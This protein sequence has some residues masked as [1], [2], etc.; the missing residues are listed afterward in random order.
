MLDK[1]QR[2]K[3]L[4]MKRRALTKKCPGATHRSD[5][6]YRQ[7]Q[8]ARAWMMYL[9]YLNVKKYT[10]K[11]FSVNKEQ[12]IYGD[13]LFTTGEIG[14]ITRYLKENKLISIDPWNYYVVDW[15]K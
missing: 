12:P 5:V 3:I 13:K 9:D 11:Y 14:T 6:R 1:E 4:K 15:R 10:P 8:M 7:A 2:I